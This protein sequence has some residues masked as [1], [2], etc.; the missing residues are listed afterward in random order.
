MDAAENVTETVAPESSSSSAKAKPKAQHGDT[1]ASLAVVNVERG[2]DSS[3]GQVQMPS[4]LE[5]SGKVVKQGPDYGHYEVRFVFVMK[6][7]VLNCC[8][9]FA[10]VADETERFT[11]GSYA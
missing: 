10:T 4:A 2:A 6:Y 5:Y 8:V 9:Q 1:S 3:F 11:K 7:T